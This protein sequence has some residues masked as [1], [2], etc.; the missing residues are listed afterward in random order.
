MSVEFYYG[1]VTVSR[2]IGGGAP[3]L[4]NA[5][6]GTLVRF[7]VAGQDPPPPGRIVEF[8]GETASSRTFVVDMSKLEALGPLL[9][10]FCSVPKPAKVSSIPDTSDVWTQLTLE[11]DWGAS[12]NCLH[13]TMQ[14]SGFEGADAPL[15]RRILV[16]IADIAGLPKGSL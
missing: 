8:S 15:V 11:V 6:T 9:V 4:S 10:A 7:T 3:G 12:R 5:Y 1:Q 13:V 14:S 2:L 16:G